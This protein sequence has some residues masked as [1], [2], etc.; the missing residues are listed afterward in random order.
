MVTATADELCR[1][2]CEQPRTA[3]GMGY[4]ALVTSQPGPDRAN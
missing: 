1:P 2:L 4:R 3:L